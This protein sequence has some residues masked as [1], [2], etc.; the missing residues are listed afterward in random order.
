MQERWKTITEAP[1]YR[2]SDSGNIYSLVN[3]MPKQAY[4]DKK[5]YIR[6]QLY[7]VGG[8]SITRKVHRL[9]AQ[10]FIKNPQ[11]LTQ[12]N[13]KNSVKSDNVHTNLEWCTNSQNMAH[14]VANGL[15]IHRKDIVDLLPQIVTAL[16]EG[17]LITD[18]VNNLGTSAKTIHRLLS[19]YNPISEPITTL[20]TG[21]KATYI[22]FDSSRKKWRTELRSF[23]LK[24]RQFNSK[25]EALSFV[26]EQLKELA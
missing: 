8:K 25:D 23:K 18:I 11:K 3:D 14:A 2:I 17:Y 21:R 5:G 6:V 22:Y 7:I 1:R 13:H 9:V 24:N 12:V 16:N 15:H 26:K 19:R 10:H 20:K 4:P